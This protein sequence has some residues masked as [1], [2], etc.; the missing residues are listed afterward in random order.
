MQ[1]RDIDVL[2][3]LDAWV[4]HLHIEIPS[5][6]VWSCHTQATNLGSMRQ[7]WIFDSCHQRVCKQRKGWFQAVGR[8]QDVKAERTVTWGTQKCLNGKQHVAK[9]LKI[10]SLNSLRISYLHAV[11]SDHIHTCPLPPLTS[12]TPSH[13]IRTV[14]PLVLVTY[15]LSAVYILGCGTIHP[16]THLTWTLKGITVIGVWPHL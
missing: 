7:W 4:S 9:I 1:R 13:P 12:Q 8:C 14:C 5:C 10:H 11:Y 16:L 15:P 6:S 3:T 2:V